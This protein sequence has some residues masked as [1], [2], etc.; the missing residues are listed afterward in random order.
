MISNKTF[1]HL[2]P[3]LCQILYQ[4]FGIFAEEF[5]YSI[6]DLHTFCPDSKDFWHSV[7]V[8]C[9]KMTPIDQRM[10]WAE[11][12][13]FCDLSINNHSDALHLDNWLLHRDLSRKFLLQRAQN[14]QNEFWT[15]WYIEVRQKKLPEIIHRYG[16]SQNSS[17]YN[18]AWAS[19]E[20]HLAN[21]ESGRWC[22]SWGAA[23]LD[24]T[25]FGWHLRNCTDQLPVIC[26][27]FACYLDGA[28]LPQHRCADNSA[29]I[30]RRALC[31]GVSDC[32]SGDDELAQ[33]C[34]NIAAQKCDDIEEIFT[35]LSSNSYGDIFP[36]GW[37]IPVTK[38]K[39]KTCL[40][41][42][43]KWLIDQKPGARIKLDFL[44]LQLGPNNRLS[45]RDLDTGEH[46]LIRQ[47]DDKFP[48]ILGAN[49]LEI[50][51]E[52][53][54]TQNGD[55]NVAERRGFHLHYAVDDANVCTR[56]F[57]SWNGSFVVPMNVPDTG[58][59]RT[60]MQCQWTIENRNRGIVVVKFPVFRLSPGDWL[61]LVLD[62]HSAHVGHNFSS[63]MPAPSVLVTN[64]PRIQFVFS[65]NNSSAGDAG[66]R[67]VFQRSCTDQ[68]IS[69]SPSGNVQISL[70][71]AIADGP[72]NCSMRIEA[73]KNGPFSLFIDYLN[74][75]ENDKIYF[76]NSDGH[77]LDN[78]SFVGIAK[79]FRSFT[80]AVLLNFVLNSSSLE[81][82]IAYSIDCDRPRLWHSAHQMAPNSNMNNSLS[83]K[84]ERLVQ[85]YLPFR[86]RI[87]SV[88]CHNSK[89]N[90]SAELI[91]ADGG[92][93]VMSGCS[94]DG[95]SAVP[96][97]ICI[98]PRIK[99]GH[100]TELNRQLGIL[101]YRCNSGFA[102]MQAQQS[103]CTKSG[104][105]IPEPKCSEIRCADP[106]PNVMPNLAFFHPP[107]RYEPAKLD[108][109]TLSNRFGNLITYKCGN[110]TM[111]RGRR[112][113]AQCSA[114]GTWTTVEIA[115]KKIGCYAMNV[116]L[117][118]FS[119]FWTL[120]GA[121]A[122]IE[123]AHGTKLATQNLPKC[124][125]D[126]NG[127]A[128]WEGIPAQG[129]KCQFENLCK[130]FG[131]NP[132]GPTGI[133]IALNGT[134]SCN[135]TSP[136]HRFNKSASFGEQCQ[137]LDECAEG[138]WPCSSG[139]CNT[140][141]HPLGRYKC[142]CPPGTHFLYDTKNKTKN[143][144][145]IPAT[146]WLIPGHS[147]IIL[148]CPTIRPLSQLFVVHSSQP[149][150]PV[151][152]TLVVYCRHNANSAL[153]GPETELKCL[154]NG[155]WNGTMP[156]RCQKAEP[157]CQAPLMPN[158]ATRIRGQKFA[159]YVVNSVVEFGCVQWTH[160]RQ[161]G[162]DFLMVGYNRSI[163]LA[164]GNWT[165]APP[166][167]I[168]PQCSKI[169][170]GIRNDGMHISLTSG[171]KWP[172]NELFGPGAEVKINC[173][174]SGKNWTMICKR[175]ANFEMVWSMDEMPKCEVNTE[176][177]A[178][179]GTCDM[180]KLAKISRDLLIASRDS[181]LV[182][183][184]V[185][186]KC[187]QPNYTLSDQK[188]RKCVKNSG[189]RAARAAVDEQLPV[190]DLPTGDQWHELIKTAMPESDVIFDSV[191]RLY[192]WQKS[193]HWT[194]NVANGSWIYW[195][196]HHGKSSLI[197]PSMEVSAG[198]WLS[199]S[200]ELGPLPCSNC[201]VWISYFA[202]DQSSSAF[203][204][205]HFNSLGA[206]MA[207]PVIHS[208]QFFS[209]HPKLRIQISA[210]DKS[211][212]F[213]VE[214]VKLISTACPAL[215]LSPVTN[216]P[217]TPAHFE[218][219]TISAQCQLGKTLRLICSPLGQWLLPENEPLAYGCG[220][221]PPLALNSHGKCGIKEAL[222]C[223]V[224]SSDTDTA[225]FSPTGAED[226]DVARATAATITK[227]CTSPDELCM[228]QSRA[229][230]AH[231]TQV[232][233]NIVRRCA[234]RAECGIFKRNVSARESCRTDLDGVE[235]CTICCSDDLC[236]GARPRQL[237]NGGG[238]VAVK[239]LMAL[240]SSTTTTT[241]ITTTLSTPTSSVLQKVTTPV[242]TSSSSTTTTSPS[243]TI[244]TITLPT[245]TAQ[246][247]TTTQ[248]IPI[249]TTRPSSTSITTMPSSH[250]VLREKQNSDEFELNSAPP[251]CV[252]QQPLDLR[253]LAQIRIRHRMD[254][255][256]PEPTVIPWPNVIDNDP[257]FHLQPMNINISKPHTFMGD[258]KEIIWRAVDLHGVVK[259]CVTKLVFDGTSSTNERQD[260]PKGIDI[261]CPDWH[262]REVNVSAEFGGDPLTD[263]PPMIRAKYPP[264]A[265]KKPDELSFDPPVGTHLALGAP[266]LVFVRLNGI[267]KCQFW[268]QTL[269]I[270]CPLW[271]LGAGNWRKFECI[272]ELN[273]LMRCKRNQPCPGGREYPR[274]MR[275]LRCWRNRP[276]HGL[277][278]TTDQKS[279]ENE[280]ISLIG[281]AQCLPEAS[282]LVVMLSIV[283]ASDNANCT[284]LMARQ[285]NSFLAQ[286]CPG[287]QWS[288]SSTNA[289]LAHS[290]L[291]GHNFGTETTDG[292][293]DQS[294]V[295]CIQR[296]SSSSRLGRPTFSGHLDMPIVEGQ[297]CPDGSVQTRHFSYHL[298]CPNGWAPN[299]LLRCEM[300]PKGHFSSNGTCAQ[301]PAG[302]FALRAGMTKCTSCPE[303]TSTVGNGTVADFQCLTRCAPG[304]FSSNN[305][306]APCR[307]CPTG[308]CQQFGKSQK[309]AESLA[310]SEMPQHFDCT[311]TGCS[312]H[313]KC[314]NGICQCDLGFVGPD[315]SILLDLCSAQFC[316]NLAKCVFDSSNGS[317][318]ICSRGFFGQRCEHSAHSN[319]L[320]TTDV[321]HLSTTSSKMQNGI[322]KESNEINECPNGFCLGGF[323]QCNA[324]FVKSTNENG[325]ICVP[326]N[327][328]LATKPCQKGATDCLHDSNGN[329]QCVCGEA[330]AGEL[331]EQQSQ[332][333]FLPQN[334]CL[335]GADCAWEIK[336]STLSTRCLCP[337][338]FN[339]ERCEHQNDQS[340]L[341]EQC[342]HEHRCG[343]NGSCQLN[344]SIGILF[345][346]CD[347]GY[348]GEFCEAEL[349][350]CSSA[351]TSPL[352]C[353]N[354]GICQ[355]MTS[356]KAVCQCPQGWTGGYC[357]GAHRGSA[358][359]SCPEGYGGDSC[360][361]EL[362]PCT[363]WP[364]GDAGICGNGH[365]L[366]KGNGHNAK[367]EC[368]CSNGWTGPNCNIPLGAKECEKTT[369]KCKNNGTCVPLIDNGIQKWTCEC[370]DGFWGN[371]C[372]KR[373]NY[374]A[375]NGICL[376]NGR[377]K[378]VVGGDN[379]Y[380]CEC[381]GKNGFF[382]QNCEQTAK[383]CD[384]NP[385][386]NGGK[387]S[388]NYADP[389]GFKCECGPN[390][391][392]E[393]NCT[394]K[395]NPCHW[396]NYCNGGQCELLPNSTDS[397]HCICP[398]DSM[399]IRCETR[400]LSHYD[401]H[402]LPFLNS[403]SSIIQ[404]IRSPSFSCLAITQQSFSLC[405]WLRFGQT[406][407]QTNK[408]FPMDLSRIIYISVNELNSADIK[409][410]QRILQFDQFGVNIFDTKLQFD[411]GHAL[412]S[413]LWHHVCLTFDTAIF[414]LFL[415]GHFVDARSGKNFSKNHSKN[416]CQLLLGEHIGE[417]AAHF[418]GQL[419]Q[420]ELYS[421]R[422]DDAQIVRMAWNCREWTHRQEKTFSIVEWAHFTTV[423]VFN[424]AQ[425][426]LFPGICSESD[427][428]PGS[429]SDC[430][431]GKNLKTPPEVLF[432]P[433]SQFITVPVPNQRLI[434]IQWEGSLE[435]MF[436]PT[437][438]SPIVRFESNF[439]PGQTFGWGQFHVVYLAE[440]ALGNWA[441]CEF[442]IVVSPTKCSDLFV[443]GTFNKLTVHQF[444]V[445]EAR[446]AE[447][448]I[449]LK[450]LSTEL[451]SNV[452]A[453]PPFYTCDRLGQWDRWANFGRPFTL[454]SCTPT[455]NAMQEVVGDLH[456]D[457]T[458]D[459]AANYVL[460]VVETIENASKNAGAFCERPQCAGQL[461]IKT[462][463]HG[464]GNGGAV[465]NNDPDVPSL[466]SG[467]GNRVRR[468]PPTGQQQQ[469]AVRV[470]FDLSVN[471]S[472]RAVAP[473][474]R[475]AMEAKFGSNF[476]GETT[477]LQ[478]SNAF[479]QLHINGDAKIAG[480]AS[481][482]MASDPPLVQCATCAPGETWQQIVRKIATTTKDESVVNSDM[483]GSC[484]KCPANSYKSSPGVQPCTPCQ[485]DR[486]T[487]GV[488][489]CMREIDCYLNCPPGSVYCSMTDTC[490]M[491]AHG[492]YMPYSGRLQCIGCPPG[493]TTEQ[494]G[495]TSADQCSVR[496]ALGEEL[497][498]GEQC[499]M[500]TRGTFRAEGMHA[501]RH[502][503][504]GFTTR[505]SGAKSASDCAHIFCPPG[506]FRNTTI[507]PDHS[508]N[509]LISS[510]ASVCV[511]CAIGY[512]QE[513]DQ[514]NDG[515]CK[516]DEPE[517]CPDGME[518][519]Q[520]RG[521][522][523]E[524]HNL[525]NI[526]RTD[527]GDVWRRVW[528][529][530]ILALFAVLALA[531]LSIIFIKNRQKW[532]LMLNRHCPC[533]F[534]LCC[535]K[536]TV[537]N[538]ASNEYT[539]TSPPIVTEIS[540]NVQQQTVVELTAASNENSRSSNTEKSKAHGHDI[541]AS[542]RPRSASESASSRSNEKVDDPLN[543]I[544]SGL[545][546]VMN[547]TELD[548]GDE[549]NGSSSS[550][551]LT[552]TFGRGQQYFMPTSSRRP[553]LTVQTRFPITPNENA[554][555]Q[556]TFHRRFRRSFSS[557]SSSSAVDEPPLVR[558]VPIHH[559]DGRSFLG[560]ARATDAIGMRNFSMGEEHN[561]D[562]TH[563]LRRPGGVLVGLRCRQFEP[564][565]GVAGGSVPLRSSLT[566]R[567]PLASPAGKSG[568]SSSGV[569]PA[570][571]TT[572]VPSYDDDDDAFFS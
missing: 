262:I 405:F 328:C 514:A 373:V 385:C 316:L 309:L 457:A 488:V 517:P 513:C 336:N 302:T 1:K 428:Q 451:V 117:G 312:G 389:T 167:C 77:G 158:V 171:Q 454:P 97:H 285:M 94:E 342:Q 397:P 314:Q 290:N 460:K 520:T 299:E 10:D 376:N 44:A 17:I 78:K 534:L 120:P 141:S 142:V 232:P 67:A 370:S 236:N 556:Q 362:S 226:A 400:K 437:G 446:Q 49:R 37:Q 9:F 8:N 98:V 18:P 524:C 415:N 435:K 2:A 453:K 54:E 211:P 96:T 15:A 497:G 122:R 172:T 270:D 160:N 213:L 147:C 55:E 228:S 183:Q 503:S 532:L 89:G 53:F 354:G 479:P 491:C 494:E 547:A 566:G 459:E 423:D 344:N 337:V 529:P 237:L 473:V 282:S 496:C 264:I 329:V 11:A 155:Q 490:T 440:D 79:E 331:C 116:E 539:R 368:L 430:G 42:R 398:P 181:V 132:C 340:D 99:N 201:M 57:E 100:A 239:S 530:M 304:T 483:S 391:V 189:K 275:E 113:M 80:S 243:S 110:G 170:L 109:R 169:A 115:C 420:V 71:K 367:F 198:D 202:A 317:S 294:V 495:S 505:S 139:T 431:H 297:Q 334:Q 23:L 567:S 310:N 194:Q 404:K 542:L 485:D 568:T 324:A 455:E 492:Q 32:E 234:E 333:C 227:R 229:H 156:T 326:I 475:D 387:C 408:A 177:V 223:H 12:N 103:I 168:L 222:L 217:R 436:R 401:L 216:F 349:N 192:G 500:C 546:E 433:R 350:P 502:C 38:F 151:N 128:Q 306:L 22:I 149:Q 476:V 107:D 548:D 301:C 549:S 210:D 101:R 434:Q 212:N 499:E 108:Y 225:C 305:G 386:A 356:E 26:Q 563:T 193:N 320:T 244:T 443:P 470:L 272:N 247:T 538:L 102:S 176:E 379:H 359:C 564:G 33:N 50:L 184:E 179:V 30:S 143:N 464:E 140:T 318:C 161:K 166:T 544:R 565:A 561:E 323:C 345:C 35:K 361:V 28:G 41:K 410:A 93:L 47:S 283:V 258:E 191:H 91:C 178:V 150:H 414:R 5:P 207:D 295:L 501:C 51:Y 126:G 447:K 144:L 322:C 407:G 508:D 7:G 14:G 81:A 267:Q 403:S 424:K 480:S 444:R 558:A 106:A 474:I 525:P 69:S 230:R 112:S 442:D 154:P 27:T 45:L 185:F 164:T 88:P 105:W 413:H 456:F 13:A 56:T 127:M 39:P 208:I 288:S 393:T 487:G 571:Q 338:G 450:C 129:I 409:N 199:V 372:E 123:C 269:S 159:E 559:R 219:Q 498:A 427:C 522:T 31:D 46:F 569:V 20:P 553:Q 76:L 248:Q 224:C 68:L 461:G 235:T 365:C 29:C 48:S 315:C 402:F 330:W 551:R 472:K 343:T 382:G 426:A 249:A 377:C 384:R 509:Q 412:I 468:V 145:I 278:Y 429:E 73:S 16:S 136:T 111:P 555:H 182:G 512:Y 321:K 3:F 92:N 286:N 478:C 510:L 482:A 383:P 74:A 196:S 469:T 293:N 90:K 63:S 281:E 484:V 366:A 481:V 543:E 358:H 348:F 394:R 570:E 254:N 467:A 6:G 260:L 465:D 308:K 518:C 220:C 449:N 448:S 536:M 335:N 238:L 533:T 554:H 242:I 61:G 327:A 146:Q 353:Y 231:G 441:T 163:C 153:I 266:K 396:P 82:N 59:Y 406:D 504:L 255:G 378:S 205:E 203:P 332:S 148:R 233:F 486:I 62:E 399:G 175:K 280:E 75:S 572:A 204:V 186:F 187:A 519:V 277:T 271:T 137:A 311:L 60:P 195:P 174:K 388:P 206:I 339:G 292:G 95:N 507:G 289:D 253:C 458:C 21:S 124:I 528:I 83:K 200:V 346:R 256:Q 560:S 52:R 284:K 162:S 347:R 265:T 421:K 245:R 273:G 515:T 131:Q 471:N 257:H 134:Y 85:N 157:F 371:R 279:G 298:Q 104:Q 19:L 527:H 463:C 552:E 375:L 263:G 562:G 363:K 241:T 65:A 521:Q 246:T 425:I 493:T 462:E 259:I 540:Q 218:N 374:C 268:Y 114:N 369:N 173:A 422:F 274:G 252:D 341:L 152:S 130:R 550:H 180:T 357:I 121:V 466:L 188:A 438:T 355:P 70:K 392:P 319:R 352:I 165:N 72:V 84:F 307:A 411:Y 390:Y 351:S 418:V 138:R 360:Q 537:D 439:R 66:F 489:G 214:R 296:V 119:H 34:D 313:G 190:G 291:T 511:P 417:E 477:R 250:F 276:G 125:L 240:S 531:V 325:Q 64:A 25:N 36:I 197:T 364:E 24:E 541:V 445:E 419:S 452:V 221:Q 395:L 215:N 86:Y 381:D 209:P 251:I 287:I 557:S 261:E 300:C 416:F 303:G 516:P 535:K 526:N 545:M 40:A 58:R 118:N 135:C 506:H 4:T 432:C 43:E 380:Q 523:Y 87:P 133:C